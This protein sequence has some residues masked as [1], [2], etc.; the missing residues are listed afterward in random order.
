MEEGVEGRV[1][2]E[3]GVWWRRTLDAAYAVWP[4][5][6]WVPMTLPTVTMH[7]PRRARSILRTMPLVK[8]MVPMRFV[9]MRAATSLGDA[10]MRRLSVLMPALLTKIS[11]VNP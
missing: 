8:S 5:P 4:A 3:K 7:P 11:G 9:L 2:G 6:P 1:C 10:R